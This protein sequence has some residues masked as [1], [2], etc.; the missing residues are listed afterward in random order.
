MPS[1]E[2][3]GANSGWGLNFLEFRTSPGNILNC[4]P[5][6][7]I[8]LV[9]NFLIPVCSLNSQFWYINI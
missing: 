8:Y 3:S 2:I 4:S 5:L 6:Y 7:L 9:L 1:I